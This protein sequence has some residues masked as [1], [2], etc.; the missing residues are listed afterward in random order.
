MPAKQP[1]IRA[2]DLAD[3]LAYL[4]VLGLYVQFFPNVISES[5]SLT[6]LTAILMKLALEI[7]TWAKKRA[8]QR[9]KR[10]DSVLARVISIGTLVLLLPG[11]KFVILWLTDL[12][13]GGAVKLGGFFALTVL[14]VVLM[15]TRAALRRVLTARGNGAQRGSLAQDGIH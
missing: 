5:F 1:A 7:I 11:S 10:A 8:L 15:L 2:V 6:L 9:F 13:F 14:I 12:V 4:V 3:V